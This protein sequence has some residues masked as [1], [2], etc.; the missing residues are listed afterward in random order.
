[1]RYDARYPTWILYSSRCEGKTGTMKILFCS[2]AAMCL[3]AGAAQ[4]ACYADY[5]AKQDDPLR[6][7][8]GVAEVQGDCSVRNAQSQ[9]RGRLAS[10]GWELLNVL[11]VFDDAQLDQ[12]KDSAGDYFL[13]F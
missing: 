2:I 9:L 10:G 5:K 11:S 7:H 13:R 4:A 1:M 12:K 3:L 6:L 8:Y